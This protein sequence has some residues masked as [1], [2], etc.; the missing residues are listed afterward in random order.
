AHRSYSTQDQVD[1]INETQKITNTY[2]KKLIHQAIKDNPKATCDEVFNNVIRLQP[3]LEKDASFKANCKKYYKREKKPHN[4]VGVNKPY[5]P[6]QM[7][8][9]ERGSYE[10]PITKMM[11]HQ[12]GRVRKPDS[13]EESNSQDDC[14][15]FSYTK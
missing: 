10:S 13:S 11:H 8:T 5:I 4:H 12:S 1:T 9:S 6:V 2:H 15:C 14:S 3:S 7:E